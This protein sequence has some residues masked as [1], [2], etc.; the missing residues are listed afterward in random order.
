[1]KTAYSAMK[2]SL[3][4]LVAAAFARADETE[5]IDGTASGTATGVPTADPAVFATTIVGT[6]CVSKLGKA[7]MTASHLIDSNTLAFSSGSVVFAGRKDSIIGTYT[8]QF[9]LTLQPGIFTF[10][11]PMLI[12]GG[13]GKFEGCSG[14][15][16][17]TGQVTSNVYP[18]RFTARF[19][20]RLVTVERERGAVTWKR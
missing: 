4:L 6:G 20:A 8:G 11:A 9:F 5:R 14:S 18:E 13:T 17:I 2:L 19:S 1:M 10:S 16:L 7:T 3:A 12:T 15:G